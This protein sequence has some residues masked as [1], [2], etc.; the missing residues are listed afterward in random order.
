M[1]HDGWQIQSSAKVGTDG[2]T[3]STTAYR[4][5]DWYRSTVPSTV[6]GSLVED[7]IYRDPFF[8]MNLRA[9]PGTTF[10][11]GANF[12]HTAMDPQSPYAVPWWCRTTFRV[13]ATMRGKRVT[14][15]F[16]GTPNIP[17]VFQIGSTLTT[18][19]ASTV[20]V[21]NGG[22][23]SAVYWDVG[24]S[25]TLGTSTTFAGN[26]L[27]E[28]FFHGGDNR[29]NLPTTQA[30]FLQS[31]GFAPTATFTFADNG[32]PVPANYLLW[33]DRVTDRLRP[34]TTSTES[35]LTASA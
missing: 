12:V 32:A 27:A 33:G 1:L 9:I 6:V 22:P 4:P 18:A 31:Y 7:S 25:A 15:N 13:P 29:T 10:P 3:I 8:G 34:L 24:S 16:D 20:N 30:G 14:L 11:I 5:T 19:S 21:I 23:N 35:P 28:K 2:A 26:I 17:F